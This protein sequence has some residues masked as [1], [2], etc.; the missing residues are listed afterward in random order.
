MWLNLKNIESVLELWHIFASRVAT[1]GFIYLEL[2]D[3]GLGSLL[4]VGIFSGAFL[5]GR[6]VLRLPKHWL[7]RI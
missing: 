4:S 7:R 3:F 1:L 5:G 2:V 6:V